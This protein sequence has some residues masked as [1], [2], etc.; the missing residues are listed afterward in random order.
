MTKEEKFELLSNK[1]NLIKRDLKNIITK[2]DLRLNPINEY[3]S[4][5]AFLS[6]DHF[7]VIDNQTWFV[8]TISEMFANCMNTED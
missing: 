1:V 8:E 4:M 3:E 7:L 2:Y 5:E 6:N